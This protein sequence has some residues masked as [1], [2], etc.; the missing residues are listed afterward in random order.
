MGRFRRFVLASSSLAVDSPLEMRT[1]YCGLKASI[2]SIF[3]AY[4]GWACRR[5]VARKG[6]VVQLLK[7]IL[8]KACL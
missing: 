7:K 5:S 8:I 1:D 6:A 3:L 2:S 4:H